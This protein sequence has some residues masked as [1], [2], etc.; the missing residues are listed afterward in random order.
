MNLQSLLDKYFIRIKAYNKQW[1]IF[2]VLEWKEY[3]VEKNWEEKKKEKK[4]EA[5]VGSF[6]S[7]LYRIM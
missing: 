6:F 4:S 7:F 1:K 3:K 5:A 2:T